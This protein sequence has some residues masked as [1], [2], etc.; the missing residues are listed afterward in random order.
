[1]MSIE[2]HTMTYNILAQY[3]GEL[4]MDVLEVSFALTKWHIVEEGDDFNYTE[5]RL[6][7][8]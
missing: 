8:K 5:H 6:N 4:W 3:L 7:E 1:M 2:S